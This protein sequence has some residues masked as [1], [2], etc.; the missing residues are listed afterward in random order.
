MT[1]QVINDWL[2][3]EKE[4]RG[5]HPRYRPA[6]D[7]LRSIA[8]LGVV[9][10]HF[11]PALMPGGFAGVD[12]FFVISGYLISLIVFRELDQGIFSFAQFYARRA[13]RLFP[14]LIVVVAS[15][16]II[17]WYSLFTDE[18]ELLGRHVYSAVLFVANFR[19]M[20]EAGYFDV[21][22]HLKPLLH[23]WSLAIEEQFY[24]VWPLL[25]VLM[26][27]LNVS[28]LKTLLIFLIFSIIA[29]AYYLNVSATTHFFNP[30]SRFWELLCGAGLAYTSLYYPS[31]LASL[32]KF[33]NAFGIVGLLLIASS[34]AFLSP[35]LIYP[36]IWAFMPVLGTALIIAARGGVVEG[37]LGWPL[38]VSIGLIS[39]PLYLWH[40][41]IFA[42]LR[43]FESGSP[44]QG[45]LFLG[46]LVSFLLA[47]I[48]YVLV[49]KKLRYKTSIF[50]TG[51][52]LFGMLM[53]FAA[54]GIV[55]V[56]K[57]FPHRAPLDYLNASTQQMVRA[58]R[59]DDSC[60]AYVL[61][62]KIPVYCR[63]ETGRELLAI[64][65]DSH[66]HVLFPG[67]AELRAQQGKGT[68]LLANSG[69]PPF[70]GS[71]FGRTALERRA[72][73]ENIERVV[74]VAER[75]PSVRQVLIASRGPQYIDGLGYGPAEK[76]YNYPPLM[77]AT[78]KAKS[79]SEVFKDGLTETV[80]RL[81]QAGKEVSYVLQVPEIGVSPRDCLGRPLHLFNQVSCNVPRSEYERR[82]KEYRDI[83]L[84]VSKE[85]NI[86]V[87]DPVNIMC[88]ESDCYIRDNVLLYADDNHLSV[89]GSRRIAPAIIGLL[90]HQGAS[91]TPYSPHQG[92]LE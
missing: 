23:L 13:R 34:Y 76:S 3:D 50:A 21:A 31:V 27:R 17:G 79:P 12:V 51:G 38:L 28:R 57:G 41:P 2:V 11:N 91:A 26:A 30:L 73:I 1:K 67:I 83:I 81:Q 4:R 64:I 54:G 8:V 5:F 49:E 63:L 48:T 44:S 65:G 7:G 20:G 32:E 71:A 9:L 53:L 45:V 75:D 92:E 62:G 46:M 6:I 18:Y 56:N 89:E 39:Y 86:R 84:S 14:A 69:C 35:A 82:M 43:I 58:P 70:I 55:A 24:F 85:R 59:F 90:N 87:L 37:L 61:P 66:A 77:D 19:L 22:S 42:Y 36:S 60:T 29:S 33:K 25:L 68:L 74:S 72:C 52:L 40:W 16:L 15:C 78:G 88:S 47:T 10:Y 80:R